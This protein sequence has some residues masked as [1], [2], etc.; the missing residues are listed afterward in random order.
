MTQ[1]RRQKSLAHTNSG[2]LR[3]PKPSVRDGVLVRPLHDL[4]DYQ[5]AVTVE[6]AVWKADG[7]D[8]V[9]IP[10]FVVALRTGGQVFGAFDGNKIVG[11][12]LA[13]A[14]WR[15]GQKFL[16]SHMTAVLESHRDH[17]I[18][19]RL[20]LFQRDDALARGIL[21]VEWTFDPLRTKNAYFNMMRLGAIA[22]TY[23]P[24]VY[25]ATSS[26]LH[27]L[28][29]TDRLVAE[30][31]LDSERVVRI[32]SGKRPTPTFSKKAVRISVPADIDHLKRT[33]PKEAARSQ[34]RIREEFLLHFKNGFA[35]TAVAPGESGVDY[36]L[37][38]WKKP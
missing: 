19:R 21:R 6:Q 5:G 36:I 16:H 12:T 15:D 13:F 11:F 2:K 33:N 27:A 25:G 26:P 23:L 18:G 24:N 1:P 17:G 28:L 30:W 22:R 7:L 31:H 3:P 4:D 10:L 29:P 20:K 32:L 8:L 9:P 34:T 35:A 14:G 37:E 38:P